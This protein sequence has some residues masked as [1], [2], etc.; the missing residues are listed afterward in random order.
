MDG[1]LSRCFPKGLDMLYTQV[2]FSDGVA[3]SRAAEGLYIPSY[4]PT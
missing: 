3:A 4:V 1:D 2:R